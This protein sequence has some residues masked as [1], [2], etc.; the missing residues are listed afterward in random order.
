LRRELRDPNNPIT[1]RDREL[2]A[3]SQVL[4]NRIVADLKRFAEVRH[5][6]FEISEQRNMPL[7]AEDRAFDKT[8]KNGIFYSWI[9][10]GALTV[11]A[12]FV[13]E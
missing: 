2:F 12:L 3:E 10:V 1:L 5:E 13:R 4:W 6:Q 9:G 7:S 8:L 11:I